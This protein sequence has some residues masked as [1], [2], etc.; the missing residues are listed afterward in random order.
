MSEII[1]TTLIWAV[2]LLFAITLH[3][4]AHGWMAYQLGDG[5]A[6]MMGRLTLNPVKHIDPIG[7]IA[8]PL[9]LFLLPVGFIFGWA[10]P[11]PVNFSALRNPKGDVFWVAIAGPLMNILMAID[12][13]IVAVLVNWAGVGV[14]LLLP[15]AAVGVFVNFL[16]AI[17]NL[18]PILPLD[19]GRMLS[20]TLPKSL[21]IH[22]DKLEPYGLFVLIALLYFGV[23]QVIIL[24]LLN[25]ALTLFSNISGVNFIYLLNILLSGG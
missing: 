16:L 20:S 1:T 18:L 19:G 25:D 24:P 10:K 6:K 3:E 5:S 23:F 8:V 21:A 12:W 14:E 15:M 17:V 4:Y 7:T 9:A 2:P 13:L 22:Y 11:V